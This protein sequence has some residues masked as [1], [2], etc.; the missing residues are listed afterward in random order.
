MA[1]R[2]AAGAPDTPTLDLVVA[3]VLSLPR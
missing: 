1:D 3:D 2:P